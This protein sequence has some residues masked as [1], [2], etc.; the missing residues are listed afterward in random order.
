MPDHITDA[1]YLELRLDPQQ[2]YFSRKSGKNKRYFYSLK[3]TTIIIALTI[4]VM[5][6]YLKENDSIKYIIS[7]LSL[8]L[9]LLA[10]LETIFQFNEKWIRDRNT[11]E[12]LKQEKFLFLSKAGPYS[13][14]ATVKELAERV[15][16]ILS[17]ENSS[18]SLLVKKTQQKKNN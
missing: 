18:W 9:A 15:E 10:G 2:K 8:M 7:I 5:S 17:K 6:G 14:T 11:S 4:P 13:T 3:T 16:T 1:E 12:A